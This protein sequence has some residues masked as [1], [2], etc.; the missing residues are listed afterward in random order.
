VGWGAVWGGGYIKALVIKANH[1]LVFLR[2]KIYKKT[3]F[4]RRGHQRNL[5]FGCS[6]DEEKVEF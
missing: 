6:L 1:I 3:Y 5:K 2:I 4:F